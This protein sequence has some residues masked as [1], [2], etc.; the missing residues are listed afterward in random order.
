MS[1]GKTK[2]Q[3]ARRQ[4]GLDDHTYRAILKRS[5]GVESSKDLTPRQVGRVLAEF[6]RLGWQPSSGKTTG[7]SPKP[8]ADLE[9]LVGKVKAQLAAAGRPVAYA[10]AMALRMYQVQRLEW[11]SAEQLR[12]IVAALAYDAKRH[13][14]LL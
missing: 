12:G 4:L 7:R 6:E 5:A 1:N 11:C 3:I 10:D 9:S 14:R 2:I 8:R 13:G